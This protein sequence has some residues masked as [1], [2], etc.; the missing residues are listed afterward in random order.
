MSEWYKH[1]VTKIPLKPCP[2]CGSNAIMLPQE[3][4]PFGKYYSVH[5]EGVC[6]VRMNCY[7]KFKKQAALNWNYRHINGGQNG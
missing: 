7:T 2:F 6:K 4:D 3:Q 5:C 1:G